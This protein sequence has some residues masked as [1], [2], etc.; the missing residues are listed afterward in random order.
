MPRPPK[1]YNGMPKMD[2]AFNGWQSS[3]SLK[4]VTQTIVDGFVTDTIQNVSYT[5]TIQPLNPELVALKPEGQRSWEWLQIHV[6][7]GQ[8]N[9]NVNDRILYND[10]EYKIM[11]VKDYSINNYL[12]YHAVY[13]YQ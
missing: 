8:Y 12:E 7:T 3:F 13:D 4:V 2:L 11:A 6:K 1:K 5:G 10:I 9:L